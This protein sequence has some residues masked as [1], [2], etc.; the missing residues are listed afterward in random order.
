MHTCLPGQVLSYST[1]TH[2]TTAEPEP[3]ICLLLLLVHRLSTV[4][5][6]FVSASSILQGLGIGLGTSA[7]TSVAGNGTGMS[8]GA[9]VY[10]ILAW[11]GVLLAKTLKNMLGTAIIHAA[12]S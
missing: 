10:C 2:V 8:T 1:V 9:C 7:I 4:L 12:L 6:S 3:H 5:A 11:R